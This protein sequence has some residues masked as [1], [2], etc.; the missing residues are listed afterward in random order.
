MGAARNTEQKFWSRVLPSPACWLWTA[1]GTNGGYGLVPWQGKTRLAH[2]LAYELRYGAIPAGACVLHRCDV[3]R[4]VR[5][6]HLFL[7]TQA[8]NIRDARKKG[9]LAQGE[10]H[11]A[12]LHP[13]SRPRGAT[14]YSR[15]EPERL[16]RGERHGCAK[17]TP[18]QVQ[19]IRCSPLSRQDLARRY[20]VSASGI[21]G[22][23]SRRTWRH[24]P[25]EER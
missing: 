21:D 16:A 3:R 8:D 1:G 9:R 7:G 20:G 25:E 17:L 19:E 14:H 6:D 13:E 2:R 24:L 15:L 12:R 18:Q 10:K 22:V 4:C 11:G 5:P 23:R